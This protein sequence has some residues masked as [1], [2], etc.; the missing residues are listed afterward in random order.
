MNNRMIS[1]SKA[2]AVSRP[3]ERGVTLVIALI[4]LMVI[5]ML[6][7]SAMRGTTLEEKMASNAQDQGLAFQAAEAALRAAIDDLSTAEATGFSDVC[8]NGY[9]TAAEGDDTDGRWEDGVLNVWGNAG[10]HQSLSGFGDGEVATQPKFIIEKLE[11]SVSVGSP[12]LV[13]GYGGAVGSTQ[14]Y[15]RLTARGTGA[16]DTA[17]A[18]V[19]T[20]YVR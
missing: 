2:G 9:C 5:S 10:K 14:N 3:S 6:G 11:Y 17:V 18:M 16:S 19:Q 1:F 13:V 7:L 8:A 20:L 15:Y 12:S 4:L